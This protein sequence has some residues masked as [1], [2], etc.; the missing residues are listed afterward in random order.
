[1]MLPD[2]HDA[3]PRQHAYA[4][5]ER[6]EVLLASMNAAL[7]RAEIP[8]IHST[9]MPEHLPIIYI[10]GVPRA[11]GT[12]LSQLVSRYLPLG[13]INNFIARF[14]LRPSVGIRLYQS[15]FGNDRRQ[16]IALRSRHGVSE[17][18]HGPHEFGYFWRHWL[19]LDR[20]PT[21]HLTSDALERLRDTGRSDGL[22]QALEQEILCTFNTGIVFKN[23]I[24]GFQAH[25]L[26]QLHPRSLFVYIRRDPFE[27][28]TSILH[29]RRE[30]YGTYEAW[31]SLKPSTFPFDVPT[32]DAAAQVARQVLDCQREFDQELSRPGVRRIEIRYDGLCQRPVAALQEI[33]AAL[34]TFD[35]GIKP[36][37]DEIPA[38]TPSEPRRLPAAMEAR[39]REC[40]LMPHAGARN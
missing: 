36:L 11:G 33:C 3:G 1:M 15:L 29:A 19:Q 9:A 16:E 10:V 28:A 2:P 12:V 8:T 31:W 22:K 37:T 39:V 34:R 23:V 26:T 17:G 38:L 5:D 30:R 32:N 20:S 21:H 13:Y 4:K 40:L 6:E 18:I 27:L 25:Y 24:C 7:E 35:V 14:W